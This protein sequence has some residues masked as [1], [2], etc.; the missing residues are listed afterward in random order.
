MIYYATQQ[1]LERYKLN[2]PENFQS[3][4]GD[5]VRMIA[6]KERGNRL[7]EWGCKLFYFDRRKCLQVVHFASKL[8][9]FLIDIKMDDIVYATNAV[10][11]YIFDIYDGDKMMKRALERYFKSSPIVVFDKITD[12]SIIAT[13]NKTQSDWAED[14]YSF[15]E[16]IINGILQTKEINRKINRDWIFTRKVNGKTEYIRSAEEFE[17]LIKENFKA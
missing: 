15:Y 9:I 16:F 17:K 8:T 7:Y 2:T 6:N 11:Q 5:I 13:L 10:A 3:E 12:R 14:G 1:T 4:T